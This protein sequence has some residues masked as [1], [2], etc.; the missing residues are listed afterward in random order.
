MLKEYLLVGEGVL[1]L[2]AVLVELQQILD[3]QRAKRVERWRLTPQESLEAVQ[4]VGIEK[5][6]ASVGACLTELCHP[7]VHNIDLFLQVVLSLRILV[8]LRDRI[9]I[10][11]FME[12]DDLGL[13]VS[14]ERELELNDLGILKWDVPV[15]EDYHAFPFMTAG[16]HN[17][18]EW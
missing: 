4:V 3:L 6:E 5:D 7:T 2:D 13:K 12:D 1:K 11:Q 8:I 15:C 16:S 9:E 10:M 17:S 14:T 18:L